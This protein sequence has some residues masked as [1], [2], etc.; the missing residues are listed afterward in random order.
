MQQFLQLLDLQLT[1]LLYIA[2][3]FFAGRKQILT[4]VG[5]DGMMS[6]L[7]NVFLPIMVFNSFKTVTIDLLLLSLQAMI[8]AVIIYSINSLIAPILYRSYP[9]EK[10]RV[11]AYGTLVNNAGFSGLPIAESIYGSTGAMMAS[12]YLAPHR[13]FMWTVGLTMLGASR[14]EGQSTLNALLKLLKNPSIIAVFIGLARGLLQINLPPF[15]ER[16]SMGIASLVAPLAMVLIGAIISQV[17]LKS[18]LEPGVLYYC[19]IRLLA[20]P[21]IV[22]MVMKGFSLDSTLT[23]VVVILAGMPIGTP[24][25]VLAAQYNLDVDFAAKLTC[26]SIILSIITV[27][28]LLSFI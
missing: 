12:V 26:V 25:T 17:C 16:A 22:L 4:H 10:A 6:I 1:L 24:T 28:L 20:I 14:K 9:E 23:G 11:M 5:R 19:F 15:I 8:A 21:L 18:L 2:L 7:I 13:L 27:P 3:G